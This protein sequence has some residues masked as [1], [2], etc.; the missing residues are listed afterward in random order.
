MC[1]TCGASCRRPALLSKSIRSAAWVICSTKPDHE[2]AARA[3]ASGPAR[4][5]SCRG[6]PCG[7]G[8]R[9]PRAPLSGLLDRRCAE[10]GR[11]QS[12]RP[13]LG[14][15]R[16]R[17]SL[18]NAPFRSSG[19]AR[20]L[21]RSGAFLY[22]VSRPDGPVIATSN[23]DVGDLVSRLPVPRDGPEYFRLRSF[24]AI[25]R[26]YFGLTVNLDS[27]VGPLRVIIARAA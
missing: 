8:D 3:L 2:I 9:D 21:Y 5:E 6:L 13:T 22:A 15:P 10:Q 14:E 1:I 4:A 20:C 19:L 11:P 18:R 24:G 25:G 17:R 7:N 23:P 12:P 16:N 27:R 26:D